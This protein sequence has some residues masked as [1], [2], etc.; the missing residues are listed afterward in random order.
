MN[1]TEE[2]LKVH[3]VPRF[4]PLETQQASEPVLPSETALKIRQQEEMLLEERKLRFE[5]ERLLREV[6]F[7]S[8]WYM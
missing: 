5:A 8:V 4:A 7:R 1:S 6:C 2:R 3:E